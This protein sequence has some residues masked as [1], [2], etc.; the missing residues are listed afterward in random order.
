MGLILLLYGL[1]TVKKGWLIAG[2]LVCGIGLGVFF[3]LQQFRSISPI[4][5]F[6][7]LIM[8]FAASWVIAFFLLRF[9]YQTTAWWALLCG[10]IFGGAG[11]TLLF[12][13]D[14]SFLRFL[15]TI[16]VPAGVVFLVWGWREKL[17]GLII[18]SCLVATT[19][20]G[21][22]MAWHRAMDPQGLVETGIMLVWFSLGWFLI[23]ILSRM[24][25][26]RSV[27]WP[28]IPGG[29]LAMVGWGLYIGGNPGNALDFVGNTGSI[30]LI[31]FGVYLLLLRFGMQK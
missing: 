14:Y 15:L 6:G 19:G 9:I 2:S 20:L 13:T 3:A 26:K 30:G 28:L 4:E 12:S 7:Y 11:Y 27:W 24:I 17:L 18:T 29:V 21:I 1:L 8:F 16:S 23:T 22:Y 25:F 31:I 10:A 5:R